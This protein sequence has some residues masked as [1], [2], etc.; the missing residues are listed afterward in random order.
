MGICIYT[1]NAKQ[2]LWLH[3]CEMKIY[4]K[5]HDYRWKFLWGS[6][7]SFTISTVNFFTT[8]KSVCAM[9]S[10]WLSLL[11]NLCNAA[12]IEWYIQLN[13]KNSRMTQ[14][15]RARNVIVFKSKQNLV[16][17]CLHAPSWK[18]WIFNHFFVGKKNEWWKIVVASDRAKGHGNNNNKKELRTVT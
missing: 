10:V 4:R 1:K 14:R 5:H 8:I 2:W 3:L 11:R 18:C 9:C 13:G 16:A 15:E 6:S 17:N 7:I 12:K